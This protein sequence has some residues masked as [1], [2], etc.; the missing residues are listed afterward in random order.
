MLSKY[1]LGRADTF[2][3]HRSQQLVCKSAD[4]DPGCGG[5]LQFVAAVLAA[6]E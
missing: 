2:V 1:P 6:D 3:V 5:N 4:L